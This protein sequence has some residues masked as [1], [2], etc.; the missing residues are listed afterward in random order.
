MQRYA[1]TKWYGNLVSY[2][3][4]VSQR[5]ID[6]LAN[7]LAYRRNYLSRLRKL[8]RKRKKITEEARKAQER[9][10]RKTKRESSPNTSHQSNRIKRSNQHHINKS[11]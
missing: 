1:D 11:Y 3:I 8:A 9:Y 2:R 10:A 6:A 5:S 4:S 7:A